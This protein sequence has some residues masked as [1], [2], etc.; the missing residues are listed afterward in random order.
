MLLN[1]ILNY[2]WVYTIASYWN[3]IELSNG[4]EWY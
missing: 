3:T 2:H 1:A 4:T